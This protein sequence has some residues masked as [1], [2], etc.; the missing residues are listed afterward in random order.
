MESPH[1]KK[2]VLWLVLEEPHILIRHFPLYIK[3]EDLESL[4]TNNLD[5][6]RDLSKFDKLAKR[7]AAASNR[8]FTAKGMRDD[9][10]L[11]KAG[12]VQVEKL[13]RNIA[14]VLDESEQKWVEEQNILTEE[15]LKQNAAHAQKA[16]EY[17][18]TLLQKCKTWGG[19]P[20]HVSM[21]L[22]HA[23]QQKVHRS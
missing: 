1:L 14:K 5:C 7:S 19:V 11:N 21:S 9:M 23:Y 12:V 15:K 2:E 18:H 8:N 10:T 4:S 6:E 20:S 3:P 17:V 13:I 16:H 22:K